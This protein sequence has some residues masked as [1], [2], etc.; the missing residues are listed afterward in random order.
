MKKISLV[1]LTSDYLNIPYKLGGT[2]REEGLDCVSFILSTAKN[3]GFDPPKTF[4]NLTLDNYIELWEKDKKLAVMTIVEWLSTW[5][6]K[7]HPNKAFVGDYLLVRGKINREMSVG[8]HSGRE[9]LAVFVEGVKL[10]KMINFTIIG[11]YR[12]CQL[13]Q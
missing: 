4:G 13:P 12:P 8:M 5:C 11:A 6:E 3:R 10:Y 1:Q 2:N 7:I 9:F